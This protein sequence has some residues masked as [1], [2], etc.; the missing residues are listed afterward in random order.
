MGGNV[1]SVA[2]HGGGDGE[3]PEVDG[4]EMSTC[5]WERLCL[6]LCLCLALNPCSLVLLNAASDV[7]SDQHRKSGL[8]AQLVARMLRTGD[9]MRS[10]VRLP[11]S[12]YIL[13]LSFLIYQPL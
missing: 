12:P 10:W 4:R 11:Q 2:E 1:K 9:C 5:G 3:A 7:F 8:L 13:C 6:D